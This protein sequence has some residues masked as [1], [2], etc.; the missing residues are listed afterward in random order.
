[1]EKKAYLIRAHGAEG[2]GVCEVP[3]GCFLVVKKQAGEGSLFPRWDEFFNCSN[4]NLNIYLNPIE[5]I[6]ELE[7]MLRTDFDVNKSLAIYRPGQKCPNFTY[8]LNFLRYEGKDSHYVMA[9]SGIYMSP[10]RL[11]D[12]SLLNFINV[13][14]DST[15]FENDFIK[16]YTGSLYPTPD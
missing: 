3:E 5:N 10:F 14:M 12:T 2:T 8:T 4:E 6:A 15:D 1:M 7:N 13:R 16:Y 11:D 9:L